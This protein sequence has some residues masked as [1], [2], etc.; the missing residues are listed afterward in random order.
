MSKNKLTSRS[1]N[2]LNLINL[3]EVAIKFKTYILC[4][5]DIKQYEE[6]I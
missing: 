2:L 1:I 6:N 5:L 3:F 4:I